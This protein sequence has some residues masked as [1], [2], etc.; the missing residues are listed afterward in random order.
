MR[1]NFALAPINIVALLQA[2]GAATG[3]I[4]RG[5][6]AAA[7][8]FKSVH[9]DK[10]SGGDYFRVNIKGNGPAR[11]QG[12]FRDF[13]ATDEH[14]VAFNG[15]QRRGVNNSFNGIRSDIQYLLRGELDL[16]FFAFRKRRFAQPKKARLE[17]AQFVRGFG[18]TRRNRAALDKNLLGQRDPDGFRRSA[19]SETGACQRSIVLT[20]LTLLVWE[21]KSDGRPRPVCRIRRAP[22]GCGA[23]RSDKYPEW[24]S[25]TVDLSAVAPAQIGRAFR[26]QSDRSTYWHVGTARGDVVAMFRGDG[27]E[28][29]LGWTPS[30]FRKTRKSRSIWSKRSWE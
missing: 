21:K 10:A 30:D 1:G 25:A 23:G 22:P 26:A 9:N 20:T 4:I 12:Q 14:F 29:Y 16:I 3:I 11:V 8:N 6:D 28:A 13:I 7:G 17:F 18:F 5:N 27:N 19:S 15:F 24:E 2:V